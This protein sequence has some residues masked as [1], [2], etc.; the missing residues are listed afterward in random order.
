MTI[1]TQ[2]MVPVNHI[3]SHCNLSGIFMLLVVEI[4]LLFVQ[5][6]ASSELFNALLLFALAAFVAGLPCYYVDAHAD[7]H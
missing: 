7:E 3:I 5:I 1:T 4:V 2:L 6:A